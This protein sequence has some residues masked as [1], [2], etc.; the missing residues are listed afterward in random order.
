MGKMIK[1]EIKSWIN[2]SVL[3]E[4]ESENNTVAKTVQKAVE[5]SADLSS[6]NLRSADLSSADLSSANL[7]SADLSSADLRS[8]NLRSADLSEIPYNHLPEFWV[9]LCSRD[10]LFVLEHLKAEVPFLKK[11]LISGEVNG[12]QYDGDCACLIGSLANAK[13]EAASKVCNV[14]PYYSLDSNNPGEQWFLNIHEGDTPQDNVFSKH[15]VK[16]CNIV[17]GLQEDDG[18]IEEKQPEIQEI[19]MNEVAKK[20]GIPVEQ[21]RIKK[22]D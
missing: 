14:I 5:S 10:I 4:Y 13:D 9:D 20:L 3:F 7:R 16:L 19:S 1:I 2:G 11:K 6:A 12:S 18:L 22:E 15:A 8:A 21:L 17:L